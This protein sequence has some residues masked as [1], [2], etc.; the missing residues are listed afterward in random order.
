MA[1]GS[2][3]GT[4]NYPA[5]KMSQSAKTLKEGIKGAPKT[6]HPNRHLSS[7]EYKR[8]LRKVEEGNE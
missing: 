4:G 6:K 1:R 5:S 3:T 2:N 8:T 7:T